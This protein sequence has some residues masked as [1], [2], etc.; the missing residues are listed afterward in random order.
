M[1]KELYDRFYYD[2]APYDGVDYIKIVSFLV[3][4][5]RFK[6]A[7]IWSKAK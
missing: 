6:T 7:L 5:N 2:T 3:S 1:N 4:E